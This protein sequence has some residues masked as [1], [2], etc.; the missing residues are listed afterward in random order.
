ME[1]VV[2]CVRFEVES[3]AS[4]HFQQCCPFSTAPVSWAVIKPTSKSDC[5]GSWPRVSY[6]CSV[7]DY[8]LEGPQRGSARA[9]LIFGATHISYSIYARLPQLHAISSPL[10][11]DIIT[12]MVLGKAMLL[13]ENMKTTQLASSYDIG[14]VFCVQNTHSGDQ[15]IL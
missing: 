15:T 4:W 9:R 6:C 1:A 3:S 14:K 7:L 8:S 2:R 11:E 12:A 13:L 10:R 5:S